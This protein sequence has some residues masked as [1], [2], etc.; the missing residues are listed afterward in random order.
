[1]MMMN[2]D[3]DYTADAY[4]R[5]HYD[6]YDRLYKEVMREF[7]NIQHHDAALLVYSRWYELDNS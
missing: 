1:M 4:A 3:P 6:T 2:N 5:D 7:P